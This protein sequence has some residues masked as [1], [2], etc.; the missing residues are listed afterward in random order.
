MCS[1]LLSGC[2]K[3]VTPGSGRSFYDLSKKRESIKLGSGFTAE[4]YLAALQYDPSKKR[5]S[6]KPMVPQ[7]CCH[8]G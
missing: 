8:H 1:Y 3:V 5:E 7:L 6:I 2:P 4:E